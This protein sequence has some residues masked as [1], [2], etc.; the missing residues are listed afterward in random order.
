MRRRDFIKG[1]IGSTAWPLAARAQSSDQVRR[2]GV[3][4]QFAKDD[5]EGISRA[6][7]LNQGFEQKGWIVGR[8]VQIDYRWSTNN[9]EKTR[10]AATELLAWPADVILANTSEAVVTLQ[11]A[12]KTTPIIFLTI[13][14]PVGQGFVKN[15]AHPG[16]NI[17]GFTQIEATVGAK[18][19]ELLKE[20][21]PQTK[22]V[23]FMSSNNPGPK[24]LS[25]SVEAAAARRAALV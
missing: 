25:R 11:S 17:T 20:I 15:L 9:V 24:Q 2:I 6:T 5:P 16:G 8:N 4:M 19:L 13:H 14:D 7:A 21:A 23:M 12:T 18:W 3:L 10:A 1:M 22:R